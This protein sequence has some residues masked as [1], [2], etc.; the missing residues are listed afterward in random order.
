MR[1]APPGSTSSIRSCPMQPGWRASCR[2]ACARCNCASRMPSAADVRRQ[3]DESLAD[4]APPRLPA[5]RQRL[6]ARGDRRRRRLCAPR[7]GGSRRRRRGGDQ[8]RRRAPRHFHAQR[9]RADNR[10]SPPQPDYVALGP[11]YETKLKAMQWAPQGLARIGAWKA[12]IGALPLVAIGGITP[13]RAD[14]V[15]AAGRRLRR[16]H[17][18]LYDS[19]R[20]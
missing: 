8:G 13:E 2:S 19:P 18:R 1:R 16:R 9:G 7:P 11:I 12:R 10:R 6:L 3:I 4:R 15:V 14:G 17:H 20:P 5:H